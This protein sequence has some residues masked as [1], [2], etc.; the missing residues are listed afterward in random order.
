MPD[1]TIGKIVYKL[2]DGQWDIPA[3]RK[4][5]E[6]ILP[7]D[8]FFHGFEVSHDF[9]D[10]GHKVILLNA[11]QIHFKEETKT[12]TLPPIIMLAMEDVTEMMGVAELLARHTNTFEEAMTKRTIKLEALLEKLEGQLDASKK[13]EDK[14]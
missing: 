8:T 4:L 6:E 12:N 3:L 2:G 9:P 5:L 11:R 14:K 10:V 7:K 1:E 13:K